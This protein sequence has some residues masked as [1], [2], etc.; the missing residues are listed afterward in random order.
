LTYYKF[1]FEF[2]WSGYDSAV[3]ATFNKKCYFWDGDVAKVTSQPNLLRK[4]LFPIAKPSGSVTTTID[5]VVG[6]LNEIITHDDC[7][8]ILG[9]CL[10]YIYNIPDISNYHLGFNYTRLVN[11]DLYF[12]PRTE[13]ILHKDRYSENK[14][15]P[16]CSQHLFDQV[17]NYD[18]V[19]N[20]I[21]DNVYK[22]MSR[23]T[24]K[25]SRLTWFNAKMG[26]PTIVPVLFQKLQEKSTILKDYF[27]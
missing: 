2:D 19:D 9:I 17:V 25:S 20:W 14:I 22:Q 10:L 27:I 21:K 15:D 18:F 26:R 3:S 4:R 16:V 5:T 7:C 13:G 1:G 12:S 6:Q 23:K 8:H 11:D 24:S